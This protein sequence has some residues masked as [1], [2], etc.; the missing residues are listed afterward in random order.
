MYDIIGDIHGQA[1]EL[2]ELLTK[3]GYG[4]IGGVN[5]PRIRR[6]LLP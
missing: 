4:R 3:L 6:R 1:G 2:E 5:S